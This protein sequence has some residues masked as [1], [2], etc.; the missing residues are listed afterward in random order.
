MNTSKTKQ[1]N[2]DIVQISSYWQK[3]VEE[4]GFSPA[5]LGEREEIKDKK[6]FN[7]LFEDLDIGNNLSVLDIGSGMGDL[8]PYLKQNKKITIT[9]YLGIDLLK[10]FIDYT[11]NKYPKRK[12]QVANFIDDSFQPTKK[13]D[14]VVAIGVLVSRVS[15]YNDFV[16]FFIQKALKFTNKFFV[17]NLVVDIDQ[18]S[19]NYEHWE[20]IGGVTYIQESDLIKIL[21]RLNADNQFTYN[22]N[23]K[24]IYEDATDAFV[25]VRMIN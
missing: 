14:L 4:H 19:P 20:E 23:K 10:E 22:I 5:G 9:D 2:S 6:F 16:E 13:F 1:W 18:S 8:I 3:K 21:D 12:F 17:F 11:Q 25:R 15:N 7:G 24:Q